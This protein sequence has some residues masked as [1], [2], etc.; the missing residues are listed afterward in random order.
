MSTGEV[1]VDDAIGAILTGA[2]I[3]IVLHDGVDITEVS[4]LGRHIPV[5]SRTAVKERDSYRCVHCGSTHRLETHHYK[6]DVAKR[7]PT[8][9]WNLATLCKYCHHLVTD[10]GFVLAGG[11][12]RWDWI[13]P[14]KRGP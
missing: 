2:F 13:E 12:G 3:K 8:A 6:I 9:D 1:P 4:H 11:P 14:T 10:C 7:G 5:E